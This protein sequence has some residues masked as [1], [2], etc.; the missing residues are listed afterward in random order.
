[1]LLLAALFFKAGPGGVF[2]GVSESVNEAVHDARVEFELVVQL[3]VEVG[4]HLLAAAD[5]VVLVLAHLLRH[6]P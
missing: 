3:E 5:V 4:D 6:L 2:G 1:M